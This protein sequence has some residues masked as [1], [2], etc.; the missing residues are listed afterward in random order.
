MRTIVNSRGIV[1]SLLLALGT[2]LGDLAAAWPAPWTTVGSAG[3]V[4]EADT[5]IVAL[6]GAEG[7]VIVPIGTSYGYG[8]TVGI[9]GSAP[10]PA[11]LNI[12]YNVVAVDG[13]SM[14]DHDLVLAVRFR[15]NGAY[16]RV[17][18]RL[19]EY[20]LNTGQIN[21]KMVFDSDTVAP[22]SGFQ[23]KAVV[24]RGCV[25]ILDFDGNAYFIDAEL[26]KTAR[27]GPSISPEGDPALGAIQLA[28]EFNIAC[29]I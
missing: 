21:V 22:A 5:N 9:T 20:N 4:D 27:T 10:L 7:G 25:P 24:L 8:A 1:L 23:W 18:V 15:D 3:T 13:L 12:R 29:G 11:T 26:I 2:G 6:G 16:A 19:K 17:I 28:P 14:Y